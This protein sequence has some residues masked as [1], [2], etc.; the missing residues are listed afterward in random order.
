MYQ[1]LEQH[2]YD[3]DDKRAQKAVIM[4]ETTTKH[5]LRHREQIAL[6]EVQP[7]PGERYKNDSANHTDG[8]CAIILM[9]FTMIISICHFYIFFNTTAERAGI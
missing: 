4:C 1:T 5:M 8:R 9:L 6:K 3:G 2:Q 7:A